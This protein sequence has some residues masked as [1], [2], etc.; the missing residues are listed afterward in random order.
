MTS[1][2]GVAESTGS[3]TLGAGDADIGVVGVESI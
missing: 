2:E 1:V 3:V